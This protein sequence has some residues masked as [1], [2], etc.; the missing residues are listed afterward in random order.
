MPIIGNVERR[1]F[2]SRLLNISIHGILLL[3]SATMIYPLLLMISGS[4]KSSVDFGKFNIIPQ[5]LYEDTALFRK[6]VVTKYNNSSIEAFKNMKDSATSLDNLEGPE[7]VT[8]PSIADYREFLKEQRPKLPHYYMGLGMSYELGIYPL[9]LR[10]FRGWLQENYGKGKKGLANCNTALGTNY[11]GW[12]EINLP[13]QNF[14]TRRADVDCSEPILAKSMEFKTT[15]TTELEACWFDIDGNFIA[16]LQRETRSRVLD[17]V[18]EKL[19]TS[20]NSWLEIC[21]SPT[22][23]ENPKLAKYWGMFVREELNI[24]FVKI[25]KTAEGAWRQFLKAKYGDLKDLN[26]IYSSKWESFE[27]IELPPT[28]PKPGQLRTDWDTFLAQKAP[29]KSLEVITLGIIYRD[30]LKK[31]YAGS[32]EAINAKYDT[33]WKS[34]EEVSLPTSL[35]DYNTKIMADWLSFTKMLNP[36][37]IGLARQSTFTYRKFVEEHYPGKENPDYGK[38]SNEYQ[39]KINATKDVPAYRNFPEASTETDYAKAHYSEAVKEERFVKMKILKVTPEIKKQWSAFLKGKYENIAKLNTEWGIVLSKWDNIPLPMKEY[40]WTL[41]KENRGLLIK[42]YLTR[43]YKMVAET[44]FNNG[45]AAVNTVIYCCL[46]VL[47][48]LLVNPLCAYALSRYRPACTYKVLLF[49]MLPIAIPGMVLGIP[50]FLL[51]K[52][53]GLLN[54]FAALIL[55]GVANGYSIFLLKGFFDSLPKELFEQAAIDGANEWTV[56]W[57]VAMRLSTPILAV[58][59]LG[60]FTAAYGNFMMAFLLCQEKS[61][62]TMMVYLYQL[63]QFASPSVGFAALIVAAIPTL[64]VF[65][66]CQNIIIKGIVVPSEK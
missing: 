26:A 64:L 7:R 62:W 12:D 66:F 8:A 1:S 46:A 35:P 32:L 28:A 20:Y 51:I 48:A 10:Q 15:R 18:N 17:Q 38:M 40:E 58:I 45:S 53:L 22:V 43:N 21:L 6:Y 44:I 13:A 63:Q 27:V 2:K 50:Q 56:F 23:P 61:M 30:W 19:G 57:N 9:A 24:Q 14:T 36:K 16:T 5:F 42:E 25:H 34:F 39:K 29:D 33:G 47:A 59:A 41:M 60:S 54:T 49:L 4:I 11:K 31:K 37:N 65:I 3:G 55:P 52:E